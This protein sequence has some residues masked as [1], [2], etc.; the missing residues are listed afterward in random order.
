MIYKSTRGEQNVRS[1]DAL[2]R[3][4]AN[5]GGLFLPTTFP[6]VKLDNLK[7]KSY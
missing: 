5:D 4:I 6:Q 3:G 7:D 2:V 1:T